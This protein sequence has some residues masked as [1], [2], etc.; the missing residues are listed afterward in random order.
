MAKQRIA[1]IGTGLIGSSIGLVLCGRKGRDYEVVGSDY[2][3]SNAKDAK[4][5]GA[6]DREVSSYKEAVKD[7]GLVILAVPVLATRPILENIAPLLDQGAVVT[8]TCSTKAAVMG[9]ADELLGPGVSFV[10]GHPM[11]GKETSGPKAASADLFKGASWAVV[12]SPR[13]TEEAVRIVHAMIILAGA[14][15]VYIDGAEHDQYV[16]GVS[17]VP[18]LLSVAL[19]R[20]ARETPGWDDA[21]I[22][23]GPAFK[24]LTRLASGAPT[25][26]GD[27]MDTNR[28]AVLHWLG[29]FREEL[30]EVEEAVKAGGEEMV[31]LFV[32]T[33]LDRD[34]FL[35]SPPQ[36]LPVGG[37]QAPNSQ[38]AMWRLFAGGLY[39]R[40][41]NV[42]E[43]TE[44]SGSEGGD[45][46]RRMG[47]RGRGR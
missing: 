8:D 37:P 9:W 38:D 31:D 1:I 15:T 24:D 30:T 3:R 11:A 26:S 32:K 27:I 2:N 33:S 43:K 41:K 42:L 34:S 6:I 12:P 21:S 46:K 29:R 23:A 44:G 16:A 25:M 45:K 13:A 47:I 18:I 28:D 36:R 19:F 40:Y 22:L 5:M 20:M 4:K 10:G 14:E 7:A 39:D 35:D 17:H